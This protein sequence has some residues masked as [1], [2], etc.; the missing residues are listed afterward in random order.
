M[1]VDQTETKIGIGSGITQPAS[2][3]FLRDST[4]FPSSTY[5][6]IFKAKFNKYIIS[7]KWKDK[8][9]YIL[10]FFKIYKDKCN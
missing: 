5:F 4:V 2:V 8:L 7:F 1:A 6:Q 9:S 3:L 10:M